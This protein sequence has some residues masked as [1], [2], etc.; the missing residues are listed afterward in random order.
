MSRDDWQYLYNSRRWRRERRAHLAAEPLCRMCKA[1]GY[2]T[3]ATVVDH[4]KP[5]KGDEFL[6]W[7]PNN[8]QSLCKVCHDS[9]KA[10]EERGGIMVGCDKD[11]V[12]L[13]PGHHWKA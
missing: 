5:H 7:D 13:D 4:V 9:A 2:T 1:Q 12:P 8:R 10:R 3:L 11:G 6:F